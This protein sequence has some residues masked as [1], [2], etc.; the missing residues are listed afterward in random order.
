MM[1]Y[2]RRI[3]PGTKARDCN[4]RA[5]LTFQ[6]SVGV[7]QVIGKRAEL[8]NYPSWKDQCYGTLGQSRK[9]KQLSALDASECSGKKTGQY[10]GADFEQIVV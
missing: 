5:A 7:G 2:T 10:G 6:K 4:S 1:A 9:A 3:D 8:T